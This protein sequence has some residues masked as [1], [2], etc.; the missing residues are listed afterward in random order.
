MG[1]ALFYLWGFKARLLAH[2]KTSTNLLLPLGFL[3]KALITVF[4]HVK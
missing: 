4:F 3:A 2:Q 1:G